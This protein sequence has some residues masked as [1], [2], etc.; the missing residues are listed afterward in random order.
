[1]PS[2]FDILGAISF[3]QGVLTL[4]ASITAAVLTALLQA[5]T[6]AFN[7]R[8]LAATIELELQS[9]ALRVFSLLQNVEDGSVTPDLRSAF[10]DCAHISRMQQELSKY[11]SRR[12]L[13]GL[14]NRDEDAEMLSKLSDRKARLVV[15]VDMP[16]TK[17]IVLELR[18]GKM[19]RK[20]YKNE[21]LREHNDPAGYFA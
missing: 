5:R 8:R 11:K 2:P 4:I 10:E 19:F 14:L 7:N 13:V 20:M 15:D 9:A 17:Q 18:L 16:S 3:A 6:V 12:I 21:R 1:M